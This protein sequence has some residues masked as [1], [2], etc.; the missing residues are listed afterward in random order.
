MNETRPEVKEEKPR[1]KRFNRPKP[2]AEDEHRQFIPLSNLLG[3]ETEI[4]PVEKDVHKHIVRQTAPAPRGWYKNKHSPK[5]VRPRPCY[6]EA[7]LTTPYS[8]YCDVGCSFC[9]SKDT[10][11]STPNGLIQISKLKIGDEVYG[12]SEN[13][14]VITK[15]MGLRPHNAERYYKITLGNE[16]ELKITGD[17]P[18]F[19]VGV[20]WVPVENL[21]IN[22]FENQE[23]EFVQ[24]LQSTN[25][26][27][28]TNP[29]QQS[30][31]YSKITPE[32]CSQGFKADLGLQ[33]RKTQTSGICREITKSHDC[34][35]VKGRES[36][37]RETEIVGMEAENGR[38]YAARGDGAEISAARP[39]SDERWNSHLIS[40]NLGISNRNL[41]RQSKSELGIRRKSIQIGQSVLVHTRFSHLPEWEAFESSRSEG[42]GKQEAPSSNQKN[43]E[44]FEY[45][46]R[47]MG[48]CEAEG[49]R[50]LRGK[51]LGIERINEPLEVFDLQTET[52]NY[53]ANGMLVKNCYVNMGTRG[54]KSTLLPTVNDEYPA[55]MDKQLAKMWITGAAYMSSY[56]EAFQTLENKYHITQRLS[57]VFNKWNVPI[58]Y[59]SRK[60]P[61]EWAMSALKSNP[62]SYMQWSINTS[63]PSDLRRLS[64][65]TFK[66]DELYAAIQKYSKAGIYTSF[67]VNPILPG[68]T[69]LDEILDLVRLIAEAGGNHVIIKFVEESSG[70][71]NVM[72]KALYDK[73]ID[74]TDYLDSV[75]TDFFGH[76][77]YVKQ[78]LRVEW[79]KEILK[80]TRSL[81]ITMATCYE[82]YKNGKSGAS[83][84]PWFN[85]ADQCH[86]PAV[87]VHYK[88]SLD[89]PFQALE[90]CFR[91]GCLYCEEFGTKACRNETLLQANALEYKD[92]RTINLND[93]LSRENDWKLPGSAPRP[94]KASTRGKN[95]GLLSDA[96]LWGLPPLDE[97]LADPSIVKEMLPS[98]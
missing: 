72:L 65:G 32:C 91:K 95:P 34:K 6:S 84:A 62:Y 56:T 82:Y 4:T 70:N 66:L 47:D 94:E 54:Y 64:P 37:E 22:G 89:Q 55:Q 13:G 1:Q 73:E 59:L 17:H 85:T 80:L 50:H 53:F 44:I 26:K 42:L 36:S 48:C 52:V 20:G 79:L 11:V 23:V 97:V 2:V 78:E 39:L 35:N 15:V 3:G 81:G 76:Q 18:I 25:S 43:A 83:I 71:R 68:I 33:Q 60:I 61:P 77:Y 67:Q 51:I 46:I 31:L 88:K 49:V 16:Q 58:F 14:V 19:V 93:G 12:R 45:S 28:S 24:V 98:Y 41:A 30:S 10:L 87:P 96:E 86:G 21:Y 90:G 5:N 9:T 74:G 57:D 40:I 69:T 7:V 38:A 75:L 8:G 63:N 92:Y 27:P 29:L